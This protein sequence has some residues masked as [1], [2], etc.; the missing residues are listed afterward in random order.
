M[1]WLSGKFIASYLGGVLVLYLQMVNYILHLQSTSNDFVR[2]TPKIFKTP[3]VAINL[4]DQPDRSIRMFPSVLT[5]V[6]LLS[7]RV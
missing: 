4:S 7:S 6:V 1:T 3:C 2:F 5:G